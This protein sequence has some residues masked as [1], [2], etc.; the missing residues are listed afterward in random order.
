MFFHGSTIFKETYQSEAKNY[1][2]IYSEQKKIKDGDNIAQAVAEEHSL[3]ALRRFVPN[4]LGF[5][6]VGSKVRL[7][8]ENLLFSAPNANI[9]D[10]KLGT[11]LITEHAREKGPDWVKHRM[12]Q[13]KKRTMIRKCGFHISGFLK[14][15]Q[16]TGALLHF[17]FKPE[18][19]EE[20]VGE[21]LS[22]IFSDSE[23]KIG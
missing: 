6:A 5:S 2:L 4:F 18:V 8:L 10:V 16:A 22:Q 23:N 3:R 11:T 19:P 17:G 14:K 7:E 9:M 1:C 15:N 20:H 21:I 13:V 12:L